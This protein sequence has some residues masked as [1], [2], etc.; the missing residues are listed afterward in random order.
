[1]VA[2][3]INGLTN[4]TLA[5]DNTGFSTWKRDGTGGTPSAIS[6]ADVF[7]Q[8]TG[9]CSVKVSN[10]GV[11]LAFEI[12]AGL[13]LSAT[14]THVYIWVNMLAGGLMHD[15]ADALPGLGIFLGYDAA[16]TGSNYDI[17]A[18]DGADT[19]PGGWVRYVIDV[20]KTATIANGTPALGDV[21]WVGMYCNTQPNVAKFDNLVID[22]IDYAVSGTG[23]RV[24]GTST[25][26]DTFQDILDADEGTVN[27]KYGVVTSKEGIIYVRGTIELGDD[28]ST[29]AATLTDTDKVVVFETPTYYDGTSEANCMADNFQQLK[30]VG[31]GTG[32]TSIT[33][34]AAVS[35]DQG[36]NGLTFIQSGS[37]VTM[38]FDDGNANTVNLYACSFRDI[39]GGLSWGTNTAHKCFSTSFSGCDQFDPVGGIQIRN[40]SFIGTASTTGAL[41][42]NSS[43]DIEDSAFIANT[44]GEGI[45][46]DTIIDVYTTG[47]VTTGGSSTAL[48]ATGSLFTGNVAVDD[49]AYNETDGSYAK[50]TTVTDNTNLVTEAL[51]DDPLVGGTGSLD[52]ANGDVYSISPAVTYT[53]LTFS[54]NTNDVTNSATGSDALFISKTGTTD[55]AT[56]TGVI[57]YIGAVTVKVTVVDSANNPIQNV[58]T[59]VILDSNGSL[60]LNADTNASGIATTSYT[61][62][63]PANCVVKCRRTSSGATRYFGKSQPATIQS[64]SGL[65]VT[66]SL[67]EDTIASA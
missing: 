11:V 25:T 4:V 46:H 13:D 5:N 16:I 61:G 56:A 27:N 33:L 32:A 34:G 31:N 24:Y 51:V 22:R 36:R 28:V 48:P 59:A 23:L 19:Y 47:T 45:E 20:S 39:T 63:T 15:R 14:D 55:P 43:I 10:Q 9:A 66:I 62:S 52:W 26:D 37:L 2:T 64:S 53:N 42:W 41:L 17:W 67:D 8:G 49:Y 60:V 40:C 1:M 12:S 6:E 38:D 58:Q 44:T 30:F 29:N 18:V 54:G 35:T 50:V 65:D 57:V 7:L 3:V 21:N